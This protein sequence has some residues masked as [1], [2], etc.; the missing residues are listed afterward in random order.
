MAEGAGCI[1]CRIA[2]G[3]V[4]AQLV[5]QDEQ[6]LAFRD[7]QPQAPVHVLV[8]PRRH[9][10]SLAEVTEGDAGLLGH[11]QVV[12]RRVAAQEGLDGSGY[13][14]VVNC[15]ADALQTVPHLHYHVLG[16]RRMG[17]PPG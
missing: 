4:P 3:E 12:I 2:A 9:V 15:G 5:Y 7:I 1:F 6:V 11:L 13:R 10:P 8:I 17:W 16:G 14:V